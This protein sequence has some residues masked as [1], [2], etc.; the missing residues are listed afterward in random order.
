HYAVTFRKVLPDDALIS[1]TSGADEPWYA[2]SFITYVD[3]REAFF[4]LASF[5]ARSMNRL[6][7]ARPHWGKYFPLNGADVERSYSRLAEFRA[8]CHA[9]DP[10]G[11]FRNEFAERVLFGA[12]GP[13]SPLSPRYS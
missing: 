11:V 4:V 8:V 5:L 10:N 3:P 12:N 6:F 9:V 2:I 7:G 13:Y 1:M